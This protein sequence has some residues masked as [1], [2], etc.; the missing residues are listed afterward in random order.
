MPLYE[1]SVINNIITYDQISFWSIQKFIYIY[2]LYY[3]DHSS[4]KLMLSG[5]L[6]TELISTM[7]KIWVSVYF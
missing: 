5:K 3:I 7:T 6:K 1:N 4:H 2:L